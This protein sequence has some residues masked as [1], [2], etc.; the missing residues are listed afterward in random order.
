VGRIHGDLLERTF[1][2]S[3]SVLE[4]MDD[5]PHSP[6][7]WLVAKQLGRSA[8]GIGANLC[9]ADHA[10]SNIDF[11]HKCN[12]ALK[13]AAETNYWLRLSRRGDLLSGELLEQCTN[14]SVELTRILST[15]VRK[16]QSPQQS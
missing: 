8:T 1:E 13:E 7:G 6:K 15:I 5:L 16:T 11:A 2:F 3:L 10:F 4:L 14:E 12:I 9:E